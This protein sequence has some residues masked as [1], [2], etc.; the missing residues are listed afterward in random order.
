[1]KLLTAA[2]LA[3]VVAFSGCALKSQRRHLFVVEIEGPKPGDF[4]GVVATSMDPKAPPANTLRF[5]SSEMTARPILIRTCGHS[6][7]YSVANNGELPVTISWNVDGASVPN[8]LSIAPG[9]LGSGQFIP[10][11]G[12]GTKR[13]KCAG[14]QS[15]SPRL[16]TGTLA[17][18]GRPR[19]GLQ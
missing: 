3:I 2:A 17:P 8:H 6:V 18:A 15:A 10:G 11:A 14:P 19:D 16:N 5:H 12:K 4:E 7:L 1:M 9:S 13:S